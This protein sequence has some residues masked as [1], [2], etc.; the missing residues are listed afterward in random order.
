MYTAILEENSE[1]LQQKIDDLVELVENE[2]EA[3][4][5]HLIE[6]VAQQELLIEKLMVRMNDFEKFEELNSAVV[7]SGMLTRHSML[8]EHYSVKANDTLL[9]DEGFHRAETSTSGKTFR[10]TKQKFYFDIPISR[11]EEK[12]FELHLPSAIKP[13]LLEDI[14]CYEDGNE[15]SMEKLDAASGA[16][17]RGVLE[18]NSRDSVTRLAFEASTAYVPK[19]L[20][21]EINDNR[22]LAVTF[23]KLIVE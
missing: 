9:P 22:E 8:K 13:E 2:P 1:Y 16:V 21:P 23:S 12:T 14:R 17:Y 18:R 7:E 20:N 6:R 3:W 11:E 4:Y 10:W 15:V 5:K 19:E